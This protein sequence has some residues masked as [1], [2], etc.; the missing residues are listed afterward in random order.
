MSLAYLRSAEGLSKFWRRYERRI[1]IIVLA[2]ALG[3]VLVTSLFLLLSGN[4]ANLNYWKKLGYPGVFLL[5]FMG[6]VSII[7]P[8]PGLIAVC[9]AGG[10]QLLPFAVGFLSGTGETLGELSGYG[11]GYGGRG[12]L[13][14]RRFYWT[15]KDWMQY[16]GGLVIFLVSL[17]PNPAFDFVGIAAG[18]LRFPLLQFLGIVWA[19]KVL[20]GV[21]VAHTCLWLARWLPWF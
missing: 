7:L 13:E 11:I 3:L 10:L 2:A 9:G 16:R 6:S 15:V 20:K 4:L 1:Q 21:I 8:V 17:I 19:G 18:G 12:V 14:K 5:S